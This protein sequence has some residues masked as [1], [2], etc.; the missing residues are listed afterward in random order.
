MTGK[1][2]INTYA[3]FAELAYRLVAPHG[4]V[5]LLVPSGI[6]SDMTTKD[7]FA[8]IAESNRLIRLF[9]FENRLKNLFPEVDGRFKFCILNFAGEQATSAKADY[10]FFAHRVEEL[11]DRSRHVSLSAAD[12]RLLNPNT[13]TCPIFRTRRDAEITKA[14]HRRVPVLI[15]NNRKGPTANPWGIQFKTMFHQTND[16]ELFHEAETLAKKGFTLA[17]NR[18]VKGKETYLPIYEAKMFRPYDHRFGTVFEDTSNWIN[19]GQTTETTLVQHQNPEHLVLP[20][21]WAL[22]SVVAAKS[23]PSLKSVSICFRDVT[24]ATDTRTFLAAVVPSVGFTNKVPLL[25]T[26]QP[27]LRELCLLASL[28]SM[29]L[30]FCT[31]QKVGGISLNFFIV[32][33]LPTLTPEAYAKPCPWDR[34]TTLETWISERVLKL[35]CTAEDMLPLADAC[36]FTSGSFQVEYGGR[37]NKWDETECAEL[38]AELDAAFFLLYGINRG[39]MEY[40]LSTFK[41]VDEPRSEFP[42]R[43]TTAQRIVQKYVEFSLPA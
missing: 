11:E 26:E 42:G 10:I 9:D 18:W 34:T 25:F 38:M 29:P 3:V 12:I 6:A 43:V 8:S 19:Q 17:G 22:E 14:I 21:W 33:Q 24:R 32:E 37:L 1:G 16:A 35:T 7:F 5:G 13:R 31:R 20:R 36:H 23:Q 28:N 27:I 40:I 4:R 41:G 15:D 30:D 2:D 39:D